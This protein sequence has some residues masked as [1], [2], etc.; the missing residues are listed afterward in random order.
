MTHNLGRFLIQEATKPA[1]STAEILTRVFTA[2]E[3]PVSIQYI[4]YY[5]G[6]AGEYLQLFLIPPN[7]MT[8]GLKPSDTSG[9]LAITSYNLLKGATGTEDA[10]STVVFANG[11]LRPDVMIPPF[12][13]MAM[14][15]S[16]GNT[17]VWVC[18]VGGFE[19]A[20]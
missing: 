3:K 18:T 19:L 17:A 1:G 6:D 11:G 20:L 13:S 7:V 15:I 4:Q 10:P 9:T 14:S 16:A 2:G 5:G 12:A 8:A